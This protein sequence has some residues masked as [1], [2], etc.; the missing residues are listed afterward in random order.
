MARKASTRHQTIVAA[1]EELKSRVS[2]KYHSH[3]LKT[4]VSKICRCLGNDY[5]INIS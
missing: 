3:H 5:K 2:S 4:D 1:R